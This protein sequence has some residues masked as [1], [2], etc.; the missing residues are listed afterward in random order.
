MADLE[1]KNIKK[2]FNGVYALRDVSFLCNKGEVHALLGENGAGKSTL[3]KVLSGAHCADSGEIIVYGK[4]VKIKNPIDAMNCG[5]GTVY[6]E[7]STIPDLTVSE[8]IFIGRMPKDKFGRIDRKKLTEMTHELFKMYDV[9]D[10]DPSAIAG[11]L[12]LSKRQMIEILRVLS[13]DPEIV[14]L[15]EATSALTEERVD[16]LLKLARKLANQQKIVIFI[17]HRMSEIRTGCDSMTILRNGESVASMPVENAD[18]SEVVALMLGNSIKDYFPQII[19]HTQNEVAL[20][21]ENVSDSKV[22]NGVDFEAYKGEV[23]GIGGLAGQG[24]TELLL[25]LFGENKVSGE[26]KLYGKKLKLRNPRQAYNR[27]IAL[28]PED[29]QLQGAITA[30]PIG[31]NISLP[32]LKLLKGAIGVN[33]KKENELVKFYMEKLKVKAVDAQMPVKSL[34]GGNQQKVILSKILST[35][36]DVLL[37]HDITRGV[38]V[39]TKKEM[40][41][42]VRKQAEEGKTVLYFSTDADELVNICDRVMVMYDGKIGVI[43]EID[44]ISRENIIAAS[45]GEKTINETGRGVVNE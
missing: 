10:I 16:W 34:S 18:L 23:L 7:L 33:T 12:S 22:L 15:D 36:P 13:K 21:V 14:I 9:T 43:L 11:E 29:R 17:S 3:L 27:G 38:D 45:I 41:D 28:V 30:L 20:S 42:M 35:H 37:L 6:Q 1:L 31:F 32:S 2:A 25:T 40:F 8:N 44:K 4:T 39:G 26:I 24:Q 19:N 5:I